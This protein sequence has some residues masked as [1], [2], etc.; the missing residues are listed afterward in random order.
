[1]RRER[2]VA[3]KSPFY[4]HKGKAA[5]MA[6]R[7]YKDI[8]ELGRAAAGLFVEIAE[9]KQGPF[10]CVL[11]GGKTPLEFFKAL[12]NE[13]FKGEVK[14]SGVHVFFGD[15]R[16][17]PPDNPESN[18]RA[19]LVNLLSAVD[20]PKENIHRMKTE[21]PPDEAA[22]E[23]EKEVSDFFGDAPKRAFDLVFLGLGADGHTLSLFP[24]TRALEEKKRL[25]VENYVERLRAWRITMTLTAINS[26]ENVVFLVSGRDKAVI[27]KDVLEG[28]SK[29]RPTPLRGIHSES[30]SGTPAGLVKPVSNEVI[31]LVTKDAASLL[32]D[33]KSLR[34]E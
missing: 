9:K 12:A 23:Y 14:W 32:R 26:S 21:L 11:P 13:P 6:V 18:Y 1:M 33:S 28:D 22:F 17:V 15:E 7:I 3:G 4:F 25:I 31:W 29:A 30:G 27:L 2:S 5:Q 16:C 24:F 8:F 10:S 34:R 20:I 19:A